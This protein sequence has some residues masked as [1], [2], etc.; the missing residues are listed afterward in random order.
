MKTGL[1]NPVLLAAAIIAAAS[2]IGYAWLFAYIQNRID[3]AS[4]SDNPLPA[5][6]VIGTIID[7]SR[8]FIPVI[9]FVLLA[10][11]A[12]KSLVMASFLTLAV[13]GI[14]VDILIDVIWAAAT[15]GSFNLGYSLWWWNPEYM[16]ANVMQAGDY[17]AIVAAVLAVIGLNIK[18]NSLATAPKF[19][20][21]TGQPI[22]QP[23][24]Q[25]VY[26][27]GSNGAP[28]SNLPQ[29]GFILAILMP[30]VGVIISHVALSQMR[31][32]QISN[33]NEKQAKNGLLIGYILMGVGFIV[34]VI[35]IIGVVIFAAASYNSYY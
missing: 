19:D 8:V 23:V 20:P 30:L 15:Q 24:A 11:N 35:V 3:W 13:F 9:I 12:K 7:Y 25:P 26:A 6:T 28:F 5:L 31:A 29:V 27:Q 2:S 1:K 14:P 22:A 33:V 10:K 17:L 18:Q 16:V 34:S 32:G 21:M 4:S